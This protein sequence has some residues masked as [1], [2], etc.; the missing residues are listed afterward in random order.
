MIP[1]L[2]YALIEIRG[3]RVTEQVAALLEELAGGDDG[4][5]AVA[6]ALRIIADPTT[7][8]VTELSGKT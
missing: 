5:A 8:P 1:E 3:E 4:D 7:A 6:T 2:V